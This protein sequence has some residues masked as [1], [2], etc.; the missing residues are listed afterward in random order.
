MLS[1]TKILLDY[2]CLYENDTVTRHQLMDFLLRFSTL[3]M[4][5]PYAT[6]KDMGVDYRF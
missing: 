4:R 6:P 5:M 2:C 1:Y 3:C